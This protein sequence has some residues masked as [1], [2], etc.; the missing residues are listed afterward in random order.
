MRDGVW[1]KGR[2]GGRGS[3]TRRTLKD[4]GEAGEAILLGL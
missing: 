1:F 2:A 4:M 3:N